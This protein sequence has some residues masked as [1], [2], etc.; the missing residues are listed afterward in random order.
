MSRCMIRARELRLHRAT[1]SIGPLCSAITDALNAVLGFQLGFVFAI[2]CF[3][4]RAVE[5]IVREMLFCS[6][7]CL[8]NVSCKSFGERT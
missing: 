2:V 6:F 1:L 3:F 7:S 4:I 8:F 5:L